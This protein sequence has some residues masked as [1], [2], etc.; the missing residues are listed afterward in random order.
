MVDVF[1]KPDYKV[2]IF[3]G[4][5]MYNEEFL[6]ALDNSPTYRR[7]AQELERMISIFSNEPVV[8]DT[9]SADDATNV[10]DKNDDE[11]ESNN[12][13]ESVGQPVFYNSLNEIT[14]TEI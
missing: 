12:E 10:F 11:E 14:E 4:D 2:Y 6:S 3:K 1:Y 13:E 5:E 9:K 8:S 7:S